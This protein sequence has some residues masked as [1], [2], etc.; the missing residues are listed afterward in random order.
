MVLGPFPTQIQV[1]WSAGQSAAS[2]QAQLPTLLLPHFRSLTSG[3][4]LPASLQCG[5][6][7]LQRLK[8]GGML[9]VKVSQLGDLKWNE[10]KRP[11]LTIC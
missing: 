9:G 11:H 5:A 4:S 3:L 1:L 2:I 8:A 7:D 10:G 6:R